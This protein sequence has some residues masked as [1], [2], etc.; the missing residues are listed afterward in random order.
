MLLVGWECNHTGDEGWDRKRTRLATIIAHGESTCMAGG[1][2]AKRARGGGGEV[3]R[4]KDFLWT[5][6]TFFTCHEARQA[7]RLV[8]MAVEKKRSLTSEC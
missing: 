8:G 3:N 1:E 6:G 2:G 5:G 4:L 7:A